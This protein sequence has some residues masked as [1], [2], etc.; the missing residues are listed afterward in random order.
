MTN[1]QCAMHFPHIYIRVYY[2]YGLTYMCIKAK[3]MCP[4]S[5][6]LTALTNHIQ[7][8]TVYFLLYIYIYI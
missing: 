3:I 8:L 1:L 2:I 7:A 4:Q 5:R 6:A